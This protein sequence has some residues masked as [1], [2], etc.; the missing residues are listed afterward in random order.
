MTVLIVAVSA[1]MLAELAVADGYRVSALDRF[2]A[3]DAPPPAASRGRRRPW[4]NAIE[5][6]AQRV[7]IAST[8]K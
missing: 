6:S 7:R 5:A 2:F 4:W 1:R 8:S 3:P